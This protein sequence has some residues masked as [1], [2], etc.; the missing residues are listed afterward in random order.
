MGQDFNQGI[1][2]PTTRVPMYANTVPIRATDSGGRGISFS[3]NEV[4]GSL[5]RGRHGWVSGFFPRKILFVPPQEE[6]FKKKLFSLHINMQFGFGAIGIWI[7]SKT[8]IYRPNKPSFPPQK[9]K[10]NGWKYFHSQLFFHRFLFSR[11]T[12]H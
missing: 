2:K 9:T 7:D 5:F 8:F 6:F 12:P 3:K 4:W 10:K 11:A 1:N